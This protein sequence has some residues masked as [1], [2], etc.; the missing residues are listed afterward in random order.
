MEVLSY[1]IPISLTLG[2]IGL[3]GFYW[4]VKSRQ[5]DDPDGDANRILSDEFDDRPKH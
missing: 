5:F 3:A 4:M 2:G 1:L